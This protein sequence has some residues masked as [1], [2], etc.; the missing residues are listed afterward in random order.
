[1]KVGADVPIPLGDR[2]NAHL[3]ALDVEYVAS[4]GERYLVPLMFTPAESAYHIHHRH[5]GTVV[6]RVRSAEGEGVLHDASAS[7]E[8]A[9]AL[10]AQIADGSRLGGDSARLVGVRHGAGADPGRELEPRVGTAE[11][12]NTSIAFGDRY[13]L[14]LVRRVEDGVNLDR[15][16]GLELNRAGFP[17]TPAVLGALELRSGR[18]A[19]TVGVLQGFVHNQGDAWAY[20]LESLER[21]FER[22]LANAQGAAPGPLPEE[23][24]LRAAQELIPESVHRAVGE[25]YLD[26]VQLLGRRTAELHHALVGVDTPDFRPEPFTSLY[27]RSL[28]QAMRNQVGQTFEALASVAPRLEGEPKRLA[29]QVLARKADLLARFRRLLDRKVEGDRIRIH[30]D[31][32][33]GQVLYT[34][35]DFVII[36]FEGEPARPLSERRLK[37]SPLRDVA[38]MLRSFDYAAAHGLAQ[39]RT[40]AVGVGER[41]GIEPWARFWQRWVSVAFLRGYFKAAGP[42]RFLPREIAERQALLDV[43]VLEKA[44]Y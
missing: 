3:L 33:L 25:S 15:E 26:A 2:A 20:T 8:F 43:F 12:S 23:P 27:Q 34:G 11:Q 44:V 6:C 28:Y 4:E 42:A 7:P 1:V 31:Y 22:T 32:H 30:G 19:P 40:V 10:L 37:R 41:D 36:D 24:S 35:K 14:K 21:F 5:P 16:M 38:G 13:I 18:R 17:C 29:E 39:A 9:H